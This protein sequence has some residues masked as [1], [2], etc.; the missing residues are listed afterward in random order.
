MNLWRSIGSYL[1]RWAK[2]ALTIAALGWFGLQVADRHVPRLATVTIGQ[3]EPAANGAASSHVVQTVA[4]EDQSAVVATTESPSTFGE[5]FREFAL[6]TS[7]LA[8][9]TFAQLAAMLAIG[10]TGGLALR[11]KVNQWREAR[12]VRSA[13]RRADRHAMDLR[14]LAAH[15]AKGNVPGPSANAIQPMKRH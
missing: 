15:D 7:V 1:D 13:R 11:P 6:A 12:A 8:A 5:L 3:P 14:L 9:N 10:V 2:F 4:Y